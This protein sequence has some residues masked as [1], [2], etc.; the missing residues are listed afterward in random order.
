[1][2]KK[3]K[4]PPAFDARTKEEGSSLNSISWA[5]LPGHTVQ[6]ILAQ[7]RQAR[8]HGHR[9][10]HLTAATRIHISHIAATETQPYVFTS[11]PCPT[12]EEVL[13]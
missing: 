1:M 13:L 4:E 2:R 6:Q 8:G 5:E 12:Q 7:W 3:K 10:P 9:V 11:S